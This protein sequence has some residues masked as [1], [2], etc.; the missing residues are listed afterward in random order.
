MWQKF[1]TAVNNSL[2]LNK[3]V[4]SSLVEDK[5]SAVQNWHGSM[6]SKDR[7]F[8]AAADYWDSVDALKFQT[9][10]KKERRGNDIPSFFKDTSSKLH[11]LH[12]PIVH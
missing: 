7:D 12:P 9:P 8:P 5:G 6:M 10:R 1:K 4:F 2:V 3:I 11:I